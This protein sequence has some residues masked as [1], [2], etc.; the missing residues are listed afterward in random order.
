MVNILYIRMSQAHELVTSPR[1]SKH[2]TF[3]CVG[4]LFPSH[5]YLERSNN[6]HT[7]PFLHI[8]FEGAS[9]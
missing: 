2:Y 1:N 7:W 8:Q 3:V 6:G 4:Q 9:K 5:V